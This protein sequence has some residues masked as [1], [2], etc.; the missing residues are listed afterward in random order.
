MTLIKTTTFHR[1][2][3]NPAPFFSDGHSKC[4]IDNFIDFDWLTLS[5]GSYAFVCLFA[6]MSR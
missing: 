5:F 3:N 6:F 1:E 2:S 4:S